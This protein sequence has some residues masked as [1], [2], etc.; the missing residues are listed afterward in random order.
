MRLQGQLAAV[1]ALVVLCLLLPRA[2]S[3]LLLATNWSAVVLVVLGVRR[4][5][6]PRRLTWW[7]VAAFVAL[8]AAGNT[9]SVL[10][11][12]DG[13]AVALTTGA[14]L[15]AA[16]AVPGL[17]GGGRRARSS[18]GGLLDLIVLVVVAVLAATEMA[19][20]GVL[21][22]DRDG[23]PWPL[24]LAPV[25]DVVLLAALL[26]LVLSRAR[27]LPAMV[28][29]VAGGF[30]CL[31]YDLL[32]TADGHRV[33]LTDEPLQAL[34]VANMLLFG[35]AARH[36]SM[37]SL[38]G[39]DAGVRARR[40][41]VQLVLLLPCALA[42]ALALLAIASGMQ[43][44]LPTAL[45]AAAAVLVALAVLARAVLALRETELGAERDALTG[46]LN[47]RGL[48]AAH[49]RASATAPVPG[50]ARWLLMVDLDDFKQ[51]ND[52]LGHSAGDALLVAV[53]RRLRGAVGRAGVVVRHGGDEFIVLVDAG[54][55]DDARWRGDPGG[56]VLDAL[57]E[58]VDV[59]GH[60]LS[61][62]ASAGVVPVVA[63]DD[64]ERSLADAD[65]AMYAAKRRSGSATCTFE[66]RLRE[67]LLGHLSAVEDL[68]AL[69]GD[70]AAPH[71]GSLQV[72]Y[73]PVVDLR[74]HRVVGVE[75]LVRWQHPERG[76]VSPDE[77]IALAEREG[78]GWRLDDAVLRTAVQQL[79]RWDGEGHRLVL[80]V[81]LGL[82]S[83]RDPDLFTRVDD[84][85]AA[86]GIDPGR[87]HLEITEHD[88][89]PDEAQ[90][91]TSMH[92]LVAAGYRLSLDDFG[93]G[94]TS[95]SYLERYPITTLKLDRSLISAHGTSSLPL[96]PGIAALA[97]TMRLELLAEGVET[98]AQAEALRGLGVHLAQGYLFAPPLPAAELT[99]LLAA[100]APLPPARLLT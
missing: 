90:V 83:M 95:L 6:P 42:P 4:H 27:L 57:R 3:E 96:V 64:L 48:A 60:A 92:E 73:Q 41:W 47:R 93:V 81:N 67:E 97:R 8:V 25:V 100:P 14:Q 84:A 59:G 55:D 53:A 58:P 76:L 49:A 34:G 77:F 19:W 71:A 69:F 91:R 15:A 11:G 7:L 33:A 16:G 32:V 86:G 88:P 70:R 9:S 12:H 36:P 38:G 82:S 13:A 89:L 39:S 66:P 72:H 79:A 45:V 23:L 94:Y 87:L 31:S 24:V 61:V 85:A 54:A 46:L 68:R 18:A 98:A 65:I 62:T 50:G 35:L 37:V 51:V 1:A 2:R 30:G 20:N 22:H 78:L 17:F 40:S 44:L 99:A 29:A 21:R 75:A 5:R 80:S 52:R 56:A 10:A 28:L 43:V 26:W 63:G 74:D